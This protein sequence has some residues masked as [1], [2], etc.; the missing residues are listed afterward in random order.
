MGLKIEE[1]Y[2]TPLRTVNTEN[3]TFIY[4]DR[5]LDLSF[6][7][8]I[9][10]KYGIDGLLYVFNYHMIQHKHNIFDVSRKFTYNDLSEDI[11]F[12]KP[13]ERFYSI[14]GFDFDDSY[15][16]I[17]KFAL[18]RGDI[19]TKFVIS[20]L[21]LTAINGF[22]YDYSGDSPRVIY[23]EDGIGSFERL[24]S[25]SL[26]CLVTS[27]TELTNVTINSIMLC[28]DMGFSLRKRQLSI[29][30]AILKY[31]NEKEFLSKLEAWIQEKHK[32]NLSNIQYDCRRFIEDLKTNKT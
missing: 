25:D 13:N 12:N 32:D 10:E 4:E 23:R 20:K 21:S 9:F 26:L 14:L 30:L 6:H 27:G 28:F 18:E 24:F 1:K 8:E 17:I 19:L 22:D 7:K 16:P 2:L 31:R 15:N 5:Y 11:K 29:I 3:Y